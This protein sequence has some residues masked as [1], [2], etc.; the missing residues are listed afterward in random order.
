MVSGTDRRRYPRFKQNDVVRITLLSEDGRSADA[1]IV[2]A[3]V[4]GI[5]LE[6]PLLF[7][8]G[9]L[10]KVEWKDTLL[11]GEVLYAQPAG[12]TNTLGIELTR[13]LYGVSEL[14]RLNSSLIGADQSKRDRNREAIAEAKPVGAA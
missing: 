13:A 12:S 11:L 6:S 4:G 5:R 10:V 3:S 8:T 1:R 7:A 2:D 14:R 9:S